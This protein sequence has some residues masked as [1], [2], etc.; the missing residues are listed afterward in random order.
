VKNKTHKYFGNLIPLIF[1]IYKNFFLG[2]VFIIY[3]FLFPLFIR[4]SKCDV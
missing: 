2:C 4:F 1:I 3:I